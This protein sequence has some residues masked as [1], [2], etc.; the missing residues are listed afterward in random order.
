MDQIQEEKENE[1]NENECSEK[2]KG[3]SHNEAFE[4]LETN[5]KWLEWQKNADS[6]K[7][8]YLRRI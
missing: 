5:M 3:S 2:K 8:T 1:E 4:S 6:I 7:L